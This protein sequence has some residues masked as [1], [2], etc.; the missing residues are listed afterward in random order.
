[1][2][3]DA[4]RRTRVCNPPGAEK[5]NAS[6]AAACKGEVEPALLWPE[7]VA[8][9]ECR[10]ADGASRTPHHQKLCDHPAKLITRYGPPV[11]HLE[12]AV[13]CPA[14]IRSQHIAIHSY[15]LGQCYWPLVTQTNV[16]THYDICWMTIVFGQMV[17][18]MMNELQPRGPQLTRTDHLEAAASYH[19]ISM[20][21]ALY[22]P[23]VE[24]YSTGFGSFMKRCT[25]SGHLLLEQTPS[26]F[27]KHFRRPQT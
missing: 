14:V 6:W 7:A 8:E 4:P 13:G 10:F 5:G 22:F 15:A 26:A 20:R 25:A 3:P 9:L 17:L 24:E 23:I 11:V 19:A 18:S 2:G 1:M 27:W 21:N 16:S 12:V